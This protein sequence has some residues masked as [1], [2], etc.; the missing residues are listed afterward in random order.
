VKAAT[1]NQ[2]LVHYFHAYNFSGGSVNDEWENIA[3]IFNGSAEMKDVNIPQN[4]RT[5]VLE[6]DQID[7]RVIRRFMGS[8]VSVPSY[9]AIILASKGI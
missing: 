4:N 2:L 5:V 3:V 9:S 8:T 1:C 6:G 7:M